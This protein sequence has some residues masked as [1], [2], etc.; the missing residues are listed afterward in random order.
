MEF[1]LTWL[2]KKTV[3]RDSKGRG[4]IVGI[5][6]QKVALIRWSL[7]TH[8][9]AEF[10]G[11][12]R[13]RSETVAIDESFH[14]E[15]KPAALKRDE[16]HVN[17]MRE[18]VKQRMTN[19]FDVA[20]HPRSLVNIST[21]LHAPTEIE[22]ALTNTFDNGNKMVKAFVNGALTMQTSTAQYQDQS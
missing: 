11:E 8:V 19:P 9:L 13:I 6:K 3:I 20:S 10:T 17:L 18:H 5:T 15:R 22:V 4:G 7:T 16:S 12:M 21:G 1:G 14:E 2:Q